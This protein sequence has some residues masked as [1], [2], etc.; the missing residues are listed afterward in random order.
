M[1]IDVLFAL[2]GSRNPVADDKLLVVAAATEHED[3]TQLAAI[4]AEIGDSA[5]ASGTYRT[6]RK[7]TLE[8][9]ESLVLAMLEA[10]PAPPTV[11]REAVRL[12]LGTLH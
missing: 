6:I 8:L 2:P 3:P 9:D 10:E 12:R 1:K 11:V 7:V 4:I 5:V